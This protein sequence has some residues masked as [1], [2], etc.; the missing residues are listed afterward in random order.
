MIN[1]EAQAELW[2]VC[3]DMKVGDERSKPLLSS[4]IDIKNTIQIR[5]KLKITRKHT[6][7][8]IQLLFKAANLRLTSEWYVSEL[9]DTDATA[10]GQT[11]EYQVTSTL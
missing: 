11:V 3:M 2:V 8:V 6:K 4:R 7:Q 10:N 1:I 5:G 9:P